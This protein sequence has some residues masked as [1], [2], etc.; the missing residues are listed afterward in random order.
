MKIEVFK[1]GVNDGS[2][3]SAA[4]LNQRSSHVVSHNIFWVKAILGIK[5]INLGRG[6]LLT[7]IFG[8]PVARACNCVY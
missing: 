3:E 2:D 7:K 6:P 1:F 5:D 4:C 8:A